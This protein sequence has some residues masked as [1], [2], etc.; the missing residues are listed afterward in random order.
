MPRINPILLA[1]MVVPEITNIHVENAFCRDYSNNYLQLEFYLEIECV[2]LKAKP[3]CLVSKW[4]S[5]N[6]A[7]CSITLSLLTAQEATVLRP[8]A[9]QPSTSRHWEASIFAPGNCSF[10]SVLVTGCDLNS[11]FRTLSS[12]CILYLSRHLKCQIFNLGIVSCISSVQAGTL[13]RRRKVKSLPVPPC[14]HF[15]SGS[16]KGL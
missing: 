10:S 6:S 3:L 8:K 16:D 12:P 7:C 13:Q 4:E 9:P 11:A 1:N 14:I 15:T 5:R 2:K